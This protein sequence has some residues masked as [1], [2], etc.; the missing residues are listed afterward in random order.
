MLFQMF[1]CWRCFALEFEWSTWK[2]RLHSAICII[3]WLN[4]L[5]LIKIVKRIV[6]RIV[7]RIV[8]RIRDRPLSSI[9]PIQQSGSSKLSKLSNHLRHENGQVLWVLL[10]V[11]YMPSIAIWT[12]LNSVLIDF[13]NLCGIAGWILLFFSLS[14]LCRVCNNIYL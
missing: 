9:L 12:D 6:N 10:P 3:W 1:Q 5:E 13:L 11:P 8:K 7:N 4:Y 2:W 14:N